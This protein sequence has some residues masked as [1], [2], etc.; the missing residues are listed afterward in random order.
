VSSNEV[1]RAT[2]ELE[3]VKRTSVDGRVIS[4]FASHNA[5]RI[6]ERLAAVVE[7]GSVEVIPVTLKEVVLESL[8]RD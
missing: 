4:V 5:G 7:G 2:L 8:R 3:G 6:A 1:D